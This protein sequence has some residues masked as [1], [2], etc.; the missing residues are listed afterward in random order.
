MKYTYLVLLLFL[1]GCDYP[2]DVKHSFTNAQKDHLRVGVIHHPPFVLVE[3]DSMY[4]VEIDLIKKIAK[5]HHLQVQFYPDNETNALKKLENFELDVVAG[6]FKKNTVWRKKAG[7][8]TTYDQHHVLLV[9][10]GEN[11]LVYKIEEQL[12]KNKPYATQ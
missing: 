10:K 5:A 1:A 8:T 9:P 4:G 6:G 3:N 12:L 7:V 2:R 11:K